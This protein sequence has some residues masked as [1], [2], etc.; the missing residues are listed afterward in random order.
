MKFTQPG[1][2]RKILTTLVLLNLLVSGQSL[3]AAP[4]TVPGSRVS[5]E[6]PEGFEKAGNFSGFQNPQKRASIMVTEM[7]GPYAQITAGFDN[8]HLSTRGMSLCSK[9]PHKVGSFD[10]VLVELTQTAGEA[11]FHKWILAF[12]DQNNT[13]LVT[14]AFPEELKQELSGKMK[15]AVLSTSFDANRAAPLNQSDLNYTV[16]PVPGMK[17]A[18]RVQNMLLFNPSGGL[19]KQKVEKPEPLF[20]AAQALNDLNIDD[21]ALFCRRRLR[22]TK[23]LNTFEI[24]SEKDVEIAGLSGREILASAIDEKGEKTFILQTMLFGKGSYFIMQG[25]CDLS[26]QKTQEPVF[27]EIAKTFKTK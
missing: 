20:V 17:L 22:Q 13:T 5:M 27:R 8:E 10:G 25:I 2:S 21:R 23:G 1:I 26:L 11:H 15:D 19:P 14:A 24:S 4:Q 7:P 9:S 18:A 6:M 3:A 16:S 12:G